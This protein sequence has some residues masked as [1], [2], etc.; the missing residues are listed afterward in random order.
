MRSS[1]M[2]SAGPLAS[3]VLPRRSSI[4]MQSRGVRDLGDGDVAERCRR[5]HGIEA[6]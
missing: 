3:T 2:D 4:S 6:P 5:G 1:C